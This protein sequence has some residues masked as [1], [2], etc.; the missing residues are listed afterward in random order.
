MGNV[1]HKAP[2]HIP[3][4]HK[5]LSVR[6]ISQTQNKSNMYRFFF[7][8]WLLPHTLWAQSGQTESPSA[9]IE[10]IS[11]HLVGQWS[12][13]AWD[14]VLEEEWTFAE[15]RLLQHATYS[16]EGKVLYEANNFM[17][18]KAGELLL[19]TIIKNS[20][21]KIFQ[22]VSFSDSQIVFENTDY[23]NPSRVTYFLGSEGYQRKIE[24]VEPD[25]K[26]SVYTFEFVPAGS[27]GLIPRKE[28]YQHSERISQV[29]LDPS[30]N[31]LYYLSSSIPNAIL[32]KSVNNLSNTDTLFFENRVLNYVLSETELLVVT[33]GESMQLLNN[34]QAIQ[35]P[36]E[37]SAIRIHRALAS[38]GWLIELTDPDADYPFL[39]S[40]LGQEVQ[41]IRPNTYQGYQQLFFDEHGEVIAA[42]GVSKQGGNAIYIQQG[43]SFQ[44]LISSPWGAD[45]FLGGMS[46]VVSV[47]DDGQDVYFTSNASTDKSKLYRYN[48]KD[49]QSHLLLEID[50]ADLLPF[51]LSKDHQGHITSAVGLFA[52]TIRACVDRETADDF[53]WLSQELEADISFVQSLREDRTWLIRTLSGAPS[54]YYVFDRDKRELQLLI[55]EPS[56]FGEHPLAN[57]YAHHIQTEDHFKLPF[58]V[59]LPPG[60]D[61]NA[62]GV[63][64]QPLPTIFYV[65]GGPWVGVVQ[66]NTPF[67]W[68]NYQFLANRGYAVVVCEFRGTSGLGRQITEASYKQ[69]GKAMIADKM[70][71]VD[72]VVKMKI[73]DPAKL[74]VWGWSYGG[75]ATQIMLALHPERFQCG[76]SMYGISNLSSFLKL[77]FADNSWWHTAVGRL[78]KDRADI[79]AHS[80]YHLAEQIQAPLLLT[81]GSQDQRVP[82]SQVDQMTERMIELDKEVVYF[83]YEKE[84]H[85]YASAEAWT[86]YW[87]VSEHFL[88]DHLGG[89]AE[90]IGDALDVAQLKIVAGHQLI[91]EFSHQ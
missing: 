83:Y 20:N 40:V 76:I 54:S 39:Y 14:G 33:R 35:L 31:H 18:E 65:H 15:G 74:G 43:D 45:M 42:N 80:P 1:Q 53:Q 69:W 64:D 4:T 58:H 17:E 87:A 71:I 5:H 81:T 19:T 84:G 38:G 57:R 60:S 34:Q 3:H 73:A 90:A 23:R 48:R 27:Q 88:Q 50:E 70:A 63:P 25:G 61:A 62:D 2:Y 68:R 12:S 51:G 26:E 56:G 24:G 47:S 30:A 86:S 13:K 85:D 66:W 6:Q 44:R 72:T 46:K 55:Q 67:F 52:K 9:F 37:P 8:L 77:P 7:I 91:E 16:E 36:V 22:A 29:Q 41:F 10:S 28:I 49:Q 89:R 21:P 32:K 59:Y 79:A 75:Y 11:P 78:P 82:Q